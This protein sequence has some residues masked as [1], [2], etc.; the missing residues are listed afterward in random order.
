MKE[1]KFEIIIAIILMVYG[2][3]F[4][5]ILPRRYAFLLTLFLIV[6]VMFD[7]I[8]RESIKIDEVKMD[9][10]CLVGIRELSLFLGMSLYNVARYFYYDDRS[11]IKGPIIWSLMPILFHELALIYVYKE[12]EYYKKMQ[13]LLLSISSGFM[14]QN[15]IAIFS[16]YTVQHDFTDA[17][18][19]RA[20]FSYGF[21]NKEPATY[22]EFYPIIFAVLVI[23]CIYTVK[24]N[25]K[26]KYFIIVSGTL[27]T[28]WFLVVTDSK[29]VFLVV[30]LTVLV[31]SFIIY[32]VKVSEGIKV[33]KLMSRAKICL[34]LLLIG[35]LAYS[36]CYFN[37]IFGLKDW[38]AQS[39]FARSG[40]IFNNVRVKISLQVL[41]DLKDF[42]LGN[43]HNIYYGRGT[44]HVSWTNV[45]K[46][47]GII[48]FSLLIIYLIFTFKD[49]VD[50]VK[51]KTIDLQVK[52][53]LVSAFMGVFLYSCI[54]PLI[55]MFAWYMV[56]YIGG[57]IRATVLNDKYFVEKK[58]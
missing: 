26:L 4:Q 58:D 14:L 18:S 44:T 12:K 36:I 11:N 38:Y 25:E 37:N 53:F 30:V 27:S 49:I 32:Y 10:K 47:A 19:Y 51:T 9:I 28:L 22:Y 23:W 41:R 56:M 2:Y 7:R 57:M 15:I 34:S 54:E 1:I 6:L 50:L 46:C 17:Y 52:L 39:M 48:P 24:E 16:Y 8:K 21:W 33:N 31:D 42:P 40:G 43:N 20:W 45:A 55:E 35:I 3:C 13:I 5:I 29:T